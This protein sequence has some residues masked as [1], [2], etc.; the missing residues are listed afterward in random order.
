MRVRANVII[1]ALFLIVFAVIRVFRFL[2]ASLPLSPVF[3]LPPPPTSLLR[4][5]TLARAGPGH[6]TAES[7]LA[8]SVCRQQRC[9]MSDAAH[10]IV[11]AAIRCAAAVSRK[12]H[13]IGL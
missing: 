4:S 1:F 9:R 10:C 11:R 13:G 5:L 3:P 2:C 7:H 8:T 12:Q 6:L